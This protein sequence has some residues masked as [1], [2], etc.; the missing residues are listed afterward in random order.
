MGILDKL[1]PQ[2][3][4]THP[5]PN[6]RIEAIHEL[7]PGDL[8]SLNAFAKDDADARV[9]RVAVARI[10]DASVLADIV[11]NES[12]G[13]VRDHALGQLVDQA[14]KHDAAAAMT[15][16]EA[17]AS[18]GREREL[19]T[20][21]KAA[22]SE[23]VRRAAIAA[24]REERSLGSVA[25]HGAEASARLIAIERLTDRAEIEGVALRGEHAD[26]AIAAIDK[27]TDAS[28][29]TLTAIA[30]KARTKAAQKKARTQLKAATPAAAVE[31]SG[32]A[33]KEADQQKGARPR[34]ADE[35]PL[36]G[37][38]LHPASRSVRR[39]ARGVG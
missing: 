30:E 11:R 33:F 22:G 26:A 21:A 14:G 4:S 36:V 38:R 16:V 15:A 29:D 23:E 31:E 27:L 24:I 35:R 12:E 28:V 32:P 17:L 2:S 34:G 20:V 10:G 9:R 18:L 6:I 19:A 25:R 39:G 3:K 37:W 13:S 7:D 5:D 8:E 1:R